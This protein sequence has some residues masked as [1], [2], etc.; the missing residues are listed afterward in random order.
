MYLEGFSRDPAEIITWISLCH[1]N[2]HEGKVLIASG[3]ATQA[4]T[5]T[6]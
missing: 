6:W 3:V 5:A 2:I 4:L 1:V